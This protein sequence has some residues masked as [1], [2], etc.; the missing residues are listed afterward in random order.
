[1]K[2]KSKLLGVLAGV[3]AL[4]AWFWWNGR[5]DAERGP[6]VGASARAED[7]AAQP[8]AA[9]P[10]ESLIAGDVSAERRELPAQAS[11]QPS[12]PAPAV[13]PE[14][15]LQHGRVRD[16]G[17]AP[18]AGIAVYRGESTEGAPLAITDAAGEFTWGVEYWDQLRAESDAWTTVLPAFGMGGASVI[19][20]APRERYSGLVVDE[21]GL[22]LEGAELVVQMEDA[23]A[24]A[25]LPGEARV[26][27]WRWSAR[28]GA[29]GGFV[30]DGVGWTEGLAVEGRLA[31]FES[32]RE[33]LPA[34]ST[35]ALV[36]SM[37]RPTA[38]ANSIIGRVVD[39]E[40]NAVEGAAVAFER[41]P[42]TTSAADGGFVVAIPAGAT[43]GVLWAVKA[44]HL[45]ARREFEDLA[46]ATAGPLPGDARSGLPHGG[47][48]S[49]GE[50][51]SGSE[52]PA[53]EPVTLVLGGKPLTLAGVVLDRAGGPVE[54]AK[55]F[56][57]DLTRWTGFGFIESRLTPE[58]FPGHATTDAEGRFEIAGLLAKPYTLRALHPRTLEVAERLDVDAGTKSIVLQFASTEVA[59]RV[60]GRVLDCSGQPVAGVMVFCGRISSPGVE[61]LLSPLVTDGTP[62]TDAAG[63][64]EF[65][66]LCVEGTYLLP[67]GADVANQERIPLST[68]MDLEHLVLTVSRKCSFQVL[69]ESD[70]NEADAFEV[71]DAD[72]QVLPL[73][74][75]LGNSSVSSSGGLDLAGGRSEVVYGDE[76]ARTLVLRKAQTEVRRI[77][78]R[79]SPGELQLLRL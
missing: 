66:A 37:R 43:R 31:G 67:A 19:V 70:P 41:G 17:G 28:S 30:L 48:P 74:Y 9:G 79:L 42:E 77:P 14:P 46:A 34:Q 63:A 49:T 40:G 1:M 53:R 61:R 51:T 11:E 57:W 47:E 24:R 45:P 76:R 3:I 36:L 20:V 5:G 54:A 8:A 26:T 22:A 56:T 73:G 29:D 21:R 6:A 23:A 72:G 2:A 35:S 39:S 69:L 71:L 16:T 33:P 78:I 60:A 58:S 68:A 38:D 10:L 25:L 13:A 64:F 15:K 50:P 52:G 75:D 12:T 59:R 32:V 18:I 4:A 55:V 27:A 65:P 44:G 62:V 7:P